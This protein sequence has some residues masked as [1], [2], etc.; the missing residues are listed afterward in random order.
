MWSPISAK[1]KRYVTVIHTDI[2]LNKKV[3]PKSLPD[4]KV[5]QKIRYFA[6]GRSP[7]AATFDL[8]RVRDC[9]RNWIRILGVLAV[10][11]SPSVVDVRR[12]RRVI[13][14]VNESEFR[15]AME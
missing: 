12:P 14:L 9:I 3:K 10:E 11:P 15:L 4:K 7:K 1:F 8:R 13:Q 2:E 6:P 5:K